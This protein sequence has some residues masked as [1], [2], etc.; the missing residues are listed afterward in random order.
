MSPDSCMFHN[1]SLD[2]IIQ[3][4]SLQ[5]VY[6]IL[7]VCLVNKDLLVSKIHLKLSE[8]SRAAAH[9]QS[10]HLQK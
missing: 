10:F 2:L 5:I 6:S 4:I 8:I 1:V 7:L 3:V 9:V